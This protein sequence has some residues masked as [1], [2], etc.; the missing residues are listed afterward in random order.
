[1]QVLVSIPR[2]MMS[3][4]NETY[5]ST[6]VT[7]KFGNNR[8]PISIEPWGRRTRRALEKGE[9]YCPLSKIEVKK[10]VVKTQNKK[11]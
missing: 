3:P 8:I 2:S 6:L 1:M 10:K 9:K 11:I 4:C 5:S 7:R